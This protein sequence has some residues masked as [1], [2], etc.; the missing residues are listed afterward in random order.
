MKIRKPGLRPKN[1]FNKNKL[2][3]DSKLKTRLERMSQINSENNSHKNDIGR[4]AFALFTEKP[5]YQP[6]ESV[7]ITL[8]AYDK[9]SKK[10]LTNCKDKLKLGSLKVE[11]KDANDGKISTLPGKIDDSMGVV[12]YSYQMTKDFK[13]G[14]YKVEARYDN[15][16]IDQTKFFVTSVRVR[17][18]A[19]TLDVNKDALTSNDEVIGKVTLK[20]LTKGNEYFNDGEPGEKLNYSVRVMDQNFKLLDIIEKKL[21]NGE[22]IFNF[23]TPQNLIGITDV[24]II[25]LLY[26]SPSPRD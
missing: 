8:F 23:Y 2:P 24:I 3:L 12:T 7:E 18:N 25:C 19:V 14:F 20:M 1:L 13:G 10:P 15:H 16:L 17:R 11:I 21:L 9:W 5:V 4:V 6:S 26:T 22:G